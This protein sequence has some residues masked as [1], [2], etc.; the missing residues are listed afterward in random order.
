MRVGR[1]LASSAK[2][3]KSICT[4]EFASRKHSHSQKSR[5]KAAERNRPTFNSANIENAHEK[6]EPHIDDNF[7][8]TPTG[9]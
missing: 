2:K 8:E 9:I 3:Y 1:F 6:R 5:T 7:K 4:F